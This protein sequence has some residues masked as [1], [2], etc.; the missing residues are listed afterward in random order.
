MGKPRS[1]LWTALHAL[2]C[3]LPV[4]GALIHVPDAQLF[5]VEAPSPVPELRF[6][7]WRS[8]TFQPALQ[9]WFESH[10]GFRGAM[11]R[12]DNAAYRAIGAEKHLALVIAGDD[13]TLLYRDSLLHLNTPP[14]ALPGIQKDIER[15]TG[16]L[17]SI[18][19][20]LEERG[21]KLTVVITPNKS[22][23]SW[24]SVPARYR[25]S[26]RVDLDVHAAIRA[27]LAR[28][29]VPFV[30]SNEIFASAPPA[31]REIL[32]PRTARHWTRYGACL[33]LREAMPPGTGPP[34][35]AYDL[36]PMSRL[37]SPD[38]DL[39]RLRDLWRF[40]EPSA[41]VPTLRMPPSP[42]EEARA[43]MPRVLFV[44]TSFMLTFG[45]VVHPYVK[46]ALALYY[47]KTFFDV[48]HEER[49]ELPPVDPSS[50]LWASS[51]LDRDVYILEL[52]DE[53]IGM[54]FQSKFFETFDERLGQGSR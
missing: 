11:V 7:D 39:W 46:S 10:I 18:H 12:T 49:V 33:I 37:E 2:V 4:L 30:D 38:Y 26:V 24:A 19:R 44:G 9:K 23:L 40:E 28:E 1:K 14:K 15:I 53:Y 32:F 45:E 29:G 6:A 36:R 51:V 13:G 25:P 16:H 27:S 17:A 50:S 8:E 22:M 54:E 52:I 3:L 35:C 47:N 41:I 20:K 5:G 48:T 31:E 21:S 43:Q 42:T 34:S